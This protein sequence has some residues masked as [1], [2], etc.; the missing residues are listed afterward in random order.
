MPTHVSVL[1]R[2][3]SYFLT[4]FFT[5]KK[6]LHLF[7]MPFSWKTPVGFVVTMLLEAVIDVIAIVIYVPNGAY[8]IGTCWLFSCILNDSPTLS[9]KP[10]STITIAG[11]SNAVDDTELKRSFCKMVQ[12][13]SDVKEFSSILNVI[14]RKRKPNS[15]GNSDFSRFFSDLSSNS[16]PPSND[17]PSLSFYLHWSTLRARYWYLKQKK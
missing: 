9:R 1:L 4:D 11:T 8:F 6:L 7:R 10:S 16:M 2:K 15:T 14:Q 12:F 3:Q 5:K 13:Y 17:Y